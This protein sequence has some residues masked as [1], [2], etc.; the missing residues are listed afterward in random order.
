[1]SH[2]TAYR[3]RGTL[4]RYQKALGQIAP[5]LE[6]SKI[7][8]AHL[9]K[10]GFSP[11]TLRIYRAALQGFHV[12]RGENLEFPIRMPHHEPP[13]VPADV[14]AKILDFAR[15]RPADYLV[16][17]LFSDAGL[18]REEAANLKVKNVIE[19]ALHIRGKGD[20]DRT[21]PLT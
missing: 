4:L 12:W 16:L 11:S 18:R 17:R 3:Y 15:T 14:V 9:R 7:F 20:R 13:Y 2:E 6:R 19:K 10:Q 1:V 21:I 8:L 5:T